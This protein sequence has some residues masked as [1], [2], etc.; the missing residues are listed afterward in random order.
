M[1]SSTAIRN[2]V[3]HL[4]IQIAICYQVQHVIFSRIAIYIKNPVKT[5]IVRQIHTK[6]EICYKVQHVKKN[7]LSFMTNIGEAKLI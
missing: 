5:A 7:Q 1:L 4:K 6:G 2:Q 3:R